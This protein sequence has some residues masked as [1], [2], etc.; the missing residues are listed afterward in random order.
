MIYRVESEHVGDDRFRVSVIADAETATVVLG[1][2]TARM[3]AR[4]GEPAADTDAGGKALSVT[5][6]RR[7]IRMHG[8]SA[9]VRDR[10]GNVWRWLSGPEHWWCTEVDDLGASTHE[11]PRRVDRP[12]DAQTGHSLDVTSHDGLEYS[13]DDDDIPQRQHRLPGDAG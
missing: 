13:H 4:E 8:E 3:L 6:L 9:A 5:D 10:N 11:L 7:L 1:E 2:L 12:A